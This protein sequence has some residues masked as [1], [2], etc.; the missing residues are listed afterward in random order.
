MPP[1]PLGW[2][3][4]YLHRGV[5]VVIKYHV[6]FKCIIGST[7][8]HQQDHHQ[9][10]IPSR[11]TSRRPYAFFVNKL[12]LAPVIGDSRH[13]ALSAPSAGSTLQTCDPPAT[14]TVVLQYSATIILFVCIVN[15]DCLFCPCEFLSHRLHW[16]KKKKRISVPL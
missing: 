12:S 9:H 4:V 6:I 3:A 2:V 8:S 7:T 10:R 13:V 14:T 11:D 1:I 15:Y 16:F 5:G